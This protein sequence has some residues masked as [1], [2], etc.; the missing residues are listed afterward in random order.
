MKK[1]E[2]NEQYSKTFRPA[3]GTSFSNILEKSIAADTY[4]KLKLKKIHLPVSL[5]AAATWALDF[6]KKKKAKSLVCANSH[7]SKSLIQKASEVQF[8]P[9]GTL[10][11]SFLR[12]F[13]LKI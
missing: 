1:N 5:C 10:I 8:P 13:L 2:K 11:A 6:P 9:S 4:T 3:I 12:I 7:A